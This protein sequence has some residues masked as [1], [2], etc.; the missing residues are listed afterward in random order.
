MLSGFTMS[1]QTNPVQYNNW[2]TSNSY[3]IGSSVTALG[4]LLSLATNKPIEITPQVGPSINWLNSNQ[5]LSQFLQSV[6]TTTN[7][8]SG[9]SAGIMITKPSGN[10]LY[11]SGVF[12]ESKGW[13][14][15]NNSYFIMTDNQ[16]NP[17][18]VKANVTGYSRLN[19]IT[20]PISLGIQTTGRIRLSFDIGTFISLPISETHRTTFNGIT[21]DIEPM[22]KIG[23]NIGVLANTNI[24]IPLNEKL[25]VSVDTRFLSSL[26]EAMKDQIGKSFNQSVQIL[27]GLNIKL[28]NN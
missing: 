18:L 16:G 28:N 10:M 17:S 19:Y 21:S 7:T 9:Y 8:L 2:E 1:Q 5:E 22:A 26:T 20:I 25:D 24:K 11:K 4:A 3:I 15:S 27:I 12:I 6:G 23:S 14:Y 13:S